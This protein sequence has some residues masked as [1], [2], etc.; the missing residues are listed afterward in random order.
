MTEAGGHPNRKGSFSMSLRKIIEEVEARSGRKFI[1]PE[2]YLGSGGPSSTGRPS[3]FHSHHTPR[4]PR[5]TRQMSL[6]WLG[7]PSR[8]EAAQRACG[9]DMDG[10]LYGLPLLHH[11]GCE[12][13]GR[14]SGI[15]VVG[16][17]KDGV[18]TSPLTVPPGVIGATVT[19]GME[20][21]EAHAKPRPRI[22]RNSSDSEGPRIG[23]AET[24]RPRSGSCEP[25]SGLSPSSQRL[26]A[27][28]IHML[29]DLPQ[30]NDEAFLLL[31]LSASL[32]FE[33]RFG[34]QEW[35]ERVLAMAARGR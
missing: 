1:G 11:S 34:A 7:T 30:M 32:E 18:V 9:D 4:H 20:G 31:Y 5:S 27:A 17:D 33:R 15:G 16:R 26:G 35:C 6:D 23:G 28:L 10:S 13:G 24:P 25:T 21:D 12:N 8:A 22:P 3:V 29:P 2:L 19:G 14:P